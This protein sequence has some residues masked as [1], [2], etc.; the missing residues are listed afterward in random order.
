MKRLR[1]AMQIAIGV[2]LVTGCATVAT[3]GM[4]TILVESEPAG[5]ECVLSRSGT[6]LGKVTTP[7]RLSISNGSSSVR[8]SCSKDGFHES[9]VFLRARVDP[10]SAFGNFVLGG[11]VGNLVDQQTGAD[12]RYEPSVML[13][14][15]PNAAEDASP[16]PAKVT[17]TAK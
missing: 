13:W 2:S 12:H 6:E 9:Q 14:L 3:R 5:A 17:G 10:R 7:G 1:L 11:A 4:Q 16:R 8:V 15:A